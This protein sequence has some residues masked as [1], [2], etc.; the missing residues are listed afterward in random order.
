[1]H[2]R[3]DE[4]GTSLTASVSDAH[5]EE[6][7][8]LVSTEEPEG[9]GDGL[10]AAERDDNDDDK[11][12]D[13]DSNTP[14]T[15]GVGSERN[16]EGEGGFPQHDS[17]RLEGGDG[18]DEQSPEG[19][20]TSALPQ[21]TQSLTRGGEDGGEGGEGGG[22]GTS[23]GDEG[24]TVAIVGEGT[25][26]EVESGGGGDGDGDGPTGDAVGEGGG[27]EGV[28]I[29]SPETPAGVDAGGERGVGDG[30]LAPEDVLLELSLAGTRALEGGLSSSTA[31]SSND[32]GANSDAD[33]GEVSE[34]GAGSPN[35][36]RRLTV[37]RSLFGDKKGVISSGR[38]GGQGGEEEGEEGQVGEGAVPGAMDG[39]EDSKQLDGSP[40]EVV[41]SK[42]ELE[43]QER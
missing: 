27:G 31:T 7:P 13:T 33:V 28:E 3:E 17:G 43:L 30:D 23:E 36:T 20:A 6:S 21:E 14:M 4:D 19:N 12:K 26:K 41:L 16:G 40:A 38:E 37:A 2:A 15:P 1:M 11:G 5:G 22:V 18:A 8:L 42:E 32:G 9:G 10:A 35:S 29:S 24:L 25:P 39:E 34:A